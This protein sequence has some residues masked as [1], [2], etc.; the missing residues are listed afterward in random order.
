MVQI[1]QTKFVHTERD[2]ETRL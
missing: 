2:R 1:K